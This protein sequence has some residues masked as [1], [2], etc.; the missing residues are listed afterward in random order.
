MLVMSSDEI[1]CAVQPCVSHHRREASRANLNE[2]ADRLHI[3]HSQIE[4]VLKD[5]DHGDL[6]A[7][8]SQFTADELRPPAFR[9][10]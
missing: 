2:I 6:V 4:T 7:H 9:G 8:L 5:W 10:R 1:V 3:E